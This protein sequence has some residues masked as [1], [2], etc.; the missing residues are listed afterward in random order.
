MKSTCGDFGKGYLS[1]F[2][3]QKTKTQNAKDEQMS[4][5]RKRKDISS[6]TPYGRAQ[7]QKQAYRKNVDVVMGGTQYV[8]VPRPMSATTQQAMRTGGW[9]DPGRGGEIKFIDVNIN[10]TMPLGAATFSAAQLLNGCVQGTEATQRVGRR[11]N[12]K[13]LYMRYTGEL[14]ATTTGSSPYRVLVVYDKQTNAAAPLITDVLL[15]DSFHAPNNLSNRDRFVTLVDHVT[16]TMDNDGPSTVADVIYRKINLETM[17]N[18]GNA[19][20]VGDITSGSIYIFVAQ[21]GKLI[22]LAPSF[23]Y[24]SRI[25]YTDI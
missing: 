25:K 5:M 20:T 16:V 2:A 17:F 3:S 10:L 6:A 14:N 23:V 9:A 18:T 8:P 1:K 11:I 13:S 24:R 21:C 4:A 12:L 19:G 22:A 15:A 7:G